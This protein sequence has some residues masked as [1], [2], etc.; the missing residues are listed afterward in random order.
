MNKIREKR[1]ADA[2]KAFSVFMDG[3]VS[4][5]VMELARTIADEYIVFQLAFPQATGYLSGYL[6]GIAELD[7]IESEKP[8]EDARECMNTILSCLQEWGAIEP[9]IRRAAR[10]VQQFAERYYQSRMGEK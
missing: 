8:G 9:Q 3:K 5:D 1:L 2:E 6:D 10:V 7:R 4:L